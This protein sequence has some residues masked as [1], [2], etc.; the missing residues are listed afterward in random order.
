M[1]RSFT[2]RIFGGVCGGIAG[3]LRVSTWLLR[4]LFIIL[5]PLSFGA[6]G[7]LYIV[8]WWMLPQQSL[9]QPQRTSLPTVLLAL[10]AIVIV[11]ALWAGRTM[12]WLI[13]PTG[14]EL[15]V[16]ALL[17]FVSVA[18]LLRQARN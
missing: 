13:G 1:V 18:F 3:S 8:L 11:G 5:T 14:Q 4:F 10:L 16:P 6:V 2:D 12:G 17:L 15:Y 9:A 7:A